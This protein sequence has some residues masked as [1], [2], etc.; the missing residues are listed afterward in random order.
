MYFQF[1]NNLSFEKGKTIHFNKLE[2]PAPKDAL[3]QVW[4]KLAQWF[5]RRRWTCEKFTTTTLTTTTTTTTT[6]NGQILIRKAHLS[7]WLRWAKKSGWNCLPTWTKTSQKFLY[8]Y[9]CILYR[10][11]WNPFNSR[12]KAF[13]NFTAW[14][15]KS[16]VGGYFVSL[17]I[18][19]VLMVTSSWE[20]KF[21]DKVESWNPWTLIH[22]NK[23]DYTISSANLGTHSWSVPVDLLLSLP[24]FSFHFCVSLHRDL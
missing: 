14:W 13:K 22:M 2:S 18:K 16:F 10:E 4:L 24:S 7:L 15:K 1:C 20:H 19:D 6:D 12:G 9:M 23:N 5:W 8:L 17:L 3:C 21:V 11:L